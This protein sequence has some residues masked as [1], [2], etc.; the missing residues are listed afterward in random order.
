MPQ[1]ARTEKLNQNV[2]NNRYKI[3]TSLFSAASAVGNAK[4]KNRCGV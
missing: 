4:E 2:R 3:F 1:E